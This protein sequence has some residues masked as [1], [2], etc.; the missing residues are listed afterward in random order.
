[1]MM[2]RSTLWAMLALLAGCAGTPP[3]A[4]P[5]AGTA[6]EARPA[7]RGEDGVAR[8]ARQQ[9]A[10]AETAARQS[11]WA[12]AVWAWDVVLALDPRDGSAREQRQRAREQGVAAAAER[13]GRARQARQKGDLDAATRLY[14]DAMLQWPEDAQSA[15]ALREIE[16]LRARR[17]NV[18]GYRMPGSRRM[19]AATGKAATAESLPARN[20]LEHAS[21]LAGQGDIDAAIAMLKPLVMARRPDPAVRSQLADLYWRKA[22]QL[23]DR[24]RQGAIDA[25]QHCLQLAPGHRQATAR[26]R[27]L[28]ATAPAPV[29]ARARN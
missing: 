27:Q 2:G 15:A 5:P 18:A 25:L 10:L 23:G 6:P 3:P 21:H 9:R 28:K 14:L 26:L 4:P 12:D 24:D 13:R 8:F 17:G 11:R 19:Y 22:E 16:A 7:A 20:E 1:M 29:P